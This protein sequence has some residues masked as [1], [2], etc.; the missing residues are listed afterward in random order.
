MVGQVKHQHLFYA[1]IDNKKI[2]KQWHNFDLSQVSVAKAVVAE[3]WRKRESN[4]NN[5][6]VARH[7]LAA[8]DCL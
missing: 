6:R 2:S 8:S 1:F 4:K 3:S 7:D 5:N